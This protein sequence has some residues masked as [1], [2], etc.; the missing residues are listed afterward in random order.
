M[1]SELTGTDDAYCW[2]DE[3][4]SFLIEKKGKNKTK[5]KDTKKFPFLPLLKTKIINASITFIERIG[6]NTYNITLSSK[7]K[8]DSLN[9]M[10]FYF[11]QL[12]TK[13]ISVLLNG[14]ALPIISMREYDNLPL[15]DIFNPNHHIFN[16]SL[17]FGSTEQW[18]DLTSSFTNQLFYIGDYEIDNKIPSTDFTL[19][20]KIESEQE[21]FLSLNDICI[22]CFPIVNIEKQTISLS[23]DEPIKKIAREKTNAAQG[24]EDRHK[25]FMNLLAPENNEYKLNQLTVRRFGAERFNANELL[26]LTQS[27]IH[28]YATD[29][30]AFKEFADLDFDNKM[31]ALRRQVNDIAKTIEN[32]NTIQS[33]IYLILKSES[34]STF[35]TINNRIKVSYLLTDGE[36][37]NGISA[38]C[39]ILTPRML[40][41][42]TSAILFPT[43]GGRDEITDSESIHAIAQY[44]QISKERLVTKSDIKYFCIKELITTHT[45]DKNNIKAIEINNCISKGQKNV[46][47]TI[48]IDQEI[49]TENTDTAIQTIGSDL[50]N[51]IAIRITG[52]YPVIVQIKNIYPNV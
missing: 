39:T 5:L 6:I 10:S 20:L 25:A 37:A 34:N 47:I 18:L 24:K 46:L 12:K 4:S 11:P 15:C 30:Y 50:G 44:Y 2:I 45:I 31:I 27:L 23:N 16:Q 1:H 19:Q 22:N 26:Q 52:F 17:V 14:K 42:K 40:N 29:F 43:Q 49:T 41:P 7:Y 36:Q 3:S 48:T 28:K 9:G 32:N 21:S 13:K 38:G 8:I 35:D 51:K 33:G